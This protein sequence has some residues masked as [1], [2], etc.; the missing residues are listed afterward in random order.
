MRKQTGLV[1]R[2]RSP[3]PRSQATTPTTPRPPGAE[4]ENTPL[5]ETVRNGIQHTRSTFAP[6][7]ID[8]DD[9]QWKRFFKETWRITWGTLTSSPVNFLL[10]LVP[11]GIVAGAL[12]WDAKAV[13]ILNFF[14]IVPLAALLSFATEE[15]AVKCGETI[16]GLMNATFGNAVE[17]IVSSAME[18]G[19]IVLN[20]DVHWR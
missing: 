20:A 3:N 13:F 1:T 9:P 10:V 19:T 11:V 6:P 12:G 2:G 7:D 4:D 17:L 15:L 5:L 14:A 18:K 8:S 16:G